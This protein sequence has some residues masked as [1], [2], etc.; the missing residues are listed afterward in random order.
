[1]STVRVADG[2]ITP[3]IPGRSRRRRGRRGR[4]RT[5]L[6]QRPGPPKSPRAALGRPLS[7]RS[8]QPS[9]GSACRLHSRTSARL[10]PLGPTVLSTR[11]LLIVAVALLAIIAVVVIFNYL[12]KPSGPAGWRPIRWPHERTLRATFR[13]RRRRRGHGN[14]RNLVPGDMIDIRGT[15]YRR[16][17]H[18]AAEPGRL[19]GGPR[20]SSTPG[21]ERL[22]LGRG[23]S[24]PRVVLWQELGPHNQPGPYTL[25]LGGRRY[26]SAES[27][28][29]VHLHR[30]HRRSAERSHGLSRL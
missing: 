23:R 13:R 16:P 1:M 5:R 7:A 20:T 25:D 18:A 9:A 8:A 21:P 22:D 24:R 6:R 3:G 17:G 2:A 26:A 29:A 14:P 30:Y 4:V 28:S 15:T 10:L 11:Y 19:R 12:G 27:A